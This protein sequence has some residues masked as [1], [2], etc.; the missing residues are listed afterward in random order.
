MQLL[1][2]AGTGKILRVRGTS[3]TILRKPEEEAGGDFVEIGGRKYPVV[4][5][6][7]QLWMAE[8]L[9]FVWDRLTVGKSGTSSTEPRGNYYNNDESTYGINGNRQGLLYNHF[10]ASNIPDLPAGW[11]LP[12]KSE[13]ETLITNAGDTPSTKLRAYTF[14]GS[15]DY[16]M[17][18][19]PTGLYTGNFSSE[20][21]GYYWSDTI[22]YTGS[23]YYIN[24]STAPNVNYSQYSE[25][26]EM[27]IRLVKDAT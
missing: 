9:D 7:N 21:A 13:W 16:E 12:S 4:R 24:F 2:Q 10:A 6:G 11:H 14:N 18:I 8:N 20:Y 15:D 1:R 25:T 22:R 23:Y 17:K 19:L 27:G 3:S 5:I 26:Y